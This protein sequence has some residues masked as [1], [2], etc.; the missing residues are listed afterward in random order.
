MKTRVFVVVLAVLVG[1]FFLVTG[2]EEPAPRKKPPPFDP[3][4]PASWEKAVRQR[5]GELDKVAG[6]LIK[7]AKDKTRSKDD[8]RKAITLLG[9]IGN[10]RCISFLVANMRMELP[11]KFIVTDTDRIRQRPC[12][13]ALL[14]G[15]ARKR[16]WTR[17]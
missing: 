4:K 9:E 12:T 3:K 14:G 8:R 1:G 2:A 16:N 13:Y 7:V 5:A 10:K 11:L 6:A 15:R 17:P